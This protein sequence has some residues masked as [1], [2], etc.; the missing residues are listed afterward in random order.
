[1]GPPRSKVKE[2]AAIA[3]DLSAV[4]QQPLSLQL[5]SLAVA[6][7]LFA[8]QHRLALMTLARE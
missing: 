1:L 2:M 5:A 3:F 4:G 6:F 7:G 8:V